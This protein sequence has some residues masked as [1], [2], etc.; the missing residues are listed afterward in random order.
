MPVHKICDGETVCAVHITNDEWKEGLN[1]FSNDEDFIQ[2]GTWG[3]DKG[4]RLAAH[5]HNEVPRQVGFT[6]EVLFIKQG[7]IRSTIYGLSEQQ[8][9]QFDSGA[10][11]ILIMLNGG[12]SYEVLEDNTQVL[13]VKNGP[14]MGA[15]VD[16]TRF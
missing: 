10:G 13:E 4:K 3:Y 15:E 8:V 1:F 12:H 2:V 14:Y 11:D 6:Q 9:G 5:Y 7:A 16:R